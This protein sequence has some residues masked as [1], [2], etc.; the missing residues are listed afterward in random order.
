MTWYGWY[1]PVIFFVIFFVLL[2]LCGF[3]RPGFWAKSAVKG[4]K[5]KAGLEL[6]TA[7]TPPDIDVIPPAPARGW[8]V[9]ALRTFLQTLPEDAPV[10]VFAPF[11][12]EGPYVCERTS[13]SFVDGEVRLSA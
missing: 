1:E 3:R 2:L 7:Q 4:R 9:K 11:N 8:T 6:R 13:V 12:G 10:R 5:G